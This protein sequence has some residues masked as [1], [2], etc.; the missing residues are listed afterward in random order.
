MVIFDRDTV[1]TFQIAEA[2][3]G[4]K[5]ITCMHKHYTVDE[6][7]A[8]AETHKDILPFVAVSS[9]TS[10]EDFNKTAEILARVDVPFICLDVANGYSEHVRIYKVLV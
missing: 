7:A 1:G 4:F 2:F 8:W 5:M 6:W 10:E 9:G 3:A